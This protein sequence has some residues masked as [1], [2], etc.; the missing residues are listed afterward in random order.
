MKLST[1]LVRSASALAL[2]IGIGAVHSLAE[3]PPGGW[4]EDN[5]INKGAHSCQLVSGTAC[6]GTGACEA[7]WNNPAFNCSPS[8]VGNSL[9][10]KGWRPYGTCVFDYSTG[11]CATYAPLGCSWWYVYSDQNCNSSPL[12]ALQATVNGYCP[13]P[14]LPPTPG[15]GGGEG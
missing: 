15:G 10:R 12:C 1:R 13:L 7:W 2:V 9:M 4:I 8:Q 14:A 6:F 11:Y 3:D 5:G